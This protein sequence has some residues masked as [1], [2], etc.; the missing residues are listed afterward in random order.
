VKPIEE[1]RVSD[2]C[3]DALASLETRCPGLLWASVSTRD[4]I[5][6]AS[7]GQVTNEKLSVMSGT[8]HALADGIVSEAALGACRDIILAAEGGR[9]AILSVKESTFD[10]VLAAMARPATTLGMLIS[11]CSTAC[12]DIRRTAAPRL[13]GAD[14]E[15][16]QA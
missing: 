8:M 16:V 1:D 11:C 10:L 12:D 15:L 2:A 7:V 3:R 5:E 14:Q 6:I 9:I 4:G 13:R